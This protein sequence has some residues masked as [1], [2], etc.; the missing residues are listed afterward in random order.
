M[1]FPFLNNYFLGFRL[2]QQALNLNQ[3]HV[4]LGFEVTSVQDDLS[5]T[6]KKYFVFAKATL[7]VIQSSSEAVQRFV[8]NCGSSRT[9]S[10]NSITYWKHSVPSEFI[11]DPKVQ[12]LW[13]TACYE[14]RRH[15]RSRKIRQGASMD[16][17]E[18]AKLWR[19]GGSRPTME[20]G[21]SSG[22]A[23]SIRFS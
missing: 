19:Y 1:K 6:F 12:S 8:T 4:Q 14:L 5:A 9:V 18:D 10:Q 11:L 23:F 16:G 17:E 21:S 3:H 22:G 20:L 2:K 15:R 13:T 7:V